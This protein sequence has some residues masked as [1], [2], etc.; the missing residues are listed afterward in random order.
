MTYLIVL[1]AGLISAGAAAGMLVSVG[2]PGKSGAQDV[3]KVLKKKQKEKSEVQERVQGFLDHMVDAGS[4]KKVIDDIRALEEA[5]K[6][7]RGRITITQA[8]L[9]T[10]ETRLRELEEIERELE[11]SGIETK[12][13]LNILKK[14]E[15]ELASQ[16]SLLKEKIQKSLQELES[17][18]Q[19][20]EM[21]AQAQEQVMAMK[22][23]LILTEQKID[24]LMLQIEE[25][26]EQYFI[27][28]KR[29]D[30]LD[31]EYAQLYEKFAEADSGEE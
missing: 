26:N 11:A 23:E 25:G 18:L 21:S 13:E 15:A 12:E 1:I 20:I 19:E 16:N 17:V 5:L 29:Y 31:I 27:L 14:K 2:N 9:E 24:L 7:E 6:A 28:K 4:V 3:L 8:E 22:Q 10:V 30:A